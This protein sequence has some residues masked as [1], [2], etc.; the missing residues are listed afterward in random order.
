MAS[1]SSDNRRV[2]ITIPDDLFR[3]ADAYAVKV[4]KSRSELYRE[5]LSEYLRRHDPEAITE[6]LNAVA[7]ELSRDH[8]GFVAEAGRRSLAQAE[9]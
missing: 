8:P 2:R 7:D 6:R 9:W 4:G 1:D 3:K 5:A